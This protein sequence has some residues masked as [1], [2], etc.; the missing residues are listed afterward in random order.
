[1][2]MLKM[3]FVLLYLILVS[4][5]DLIAQNKTVNNMSFE[6]KTKWLAKNITKAGYLTYQSRTGTSES[7][8]S[9]IKFDGCQVIIKKTSIYYPKPV[10]QPSDLSS[11]GTP[12]FMKNETYQVDALKQRKSVNTTSFNLADLDPEQIK[13]NWSPDEKLVALVL[14]THNEDKAVEYN[15][16]KF[17]MFFSQIQL[18]INRKSAEQ[19]SQLFKDVI[20]KCQ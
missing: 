8:I 17:P 10:T 12:D 6:Q 14:P 1:M 9:R 4:N 3:L 15:T 20:K 13:V 2:R 7:R 11:T 18:L 19:F 5:S 16:G